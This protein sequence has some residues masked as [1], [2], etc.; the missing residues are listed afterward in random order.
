MMLRENQAQILREYLERSSGMGAS[1]FECS[2][3]NGGG[4]WET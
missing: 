3:G 2:G 1:L 4:A